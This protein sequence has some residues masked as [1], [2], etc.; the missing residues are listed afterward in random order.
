MGSK[1]WSW[2]FTQT[3]GLLARSTTGRVSRLKT[4]AAVPAWLCVTPKLS[5]HL[6]VA[7]VYLC[8][9]TQMTC[10]SEVTLKRPRT[11]GCRI[12]RPVVDTMAL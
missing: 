12:V 3:A 8:I 11:P 2:E 9:H 6:S 5:S 7:S 1:P 10:C 4:L